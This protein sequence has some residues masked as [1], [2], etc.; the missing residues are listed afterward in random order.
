MALGVKEEEGVVVL[1]GDADISLIAGGGVREWGF[2]A[3][4]EGVAVVSS[5]LGVVED[6][7]IAEGHTEDL[8]QHLGGLAGGEGEGDVE[9]QHEPQQIGRA[10]DAGEV[11]GARHGSGGLQLSGLEMVLAVLVAELELREAKF[12]EEFFVPL[13]GLLFLEIVR[14]VVGRALVNRAVGLLFPAVEGAVAVGAPVT[15]FPR[16]EARRKLRQATTDLAVELR[17]PTTIVEVEEVPRGAAMRAMASSGKSARATPSDGPQGPSM[18]AL[19]IDAQ[20][21]PVQLRSWGREGGR[22][23][24]RRLGIDIKIAVVRMLLAKI[25][26]GMNLGFVPSEDLL[27]LRD[28]VFQV[29]ASKFPAE[30][31]HQ[32]CYVAHGGESLGNLAGSLH[33]DFEKRDSTAFCVLGQARFRSLAPRPNPA[34]PSAASPEKRG[35]STNP[36]FPQQFNELSA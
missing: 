12:L 22:L 3:E 23:R 8:A 6:G 20:L 27:Q 2:M 36:S 26:A 1:A 11:D 14:A 21:P 35:E 13:Q 28:E 25:V 29:L 24:E 31:E 7:L 5:G 10:M 17:G 33:G 15:S 4:V 16:A 9:S 30:P 18:G 32:T 34:K 19:I